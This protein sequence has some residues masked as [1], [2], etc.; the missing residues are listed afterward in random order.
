MISE[1]LAAQ[2]FRAVARTEAAPAELSPY[3]AE[4][5]DIGALTAIIDSEGG[6]T[7]RVVTFYQ[8]FYNRLPDGG[9]L[10]FWTGIARSD[11]N[12]SDGDLA[13]VFFGAGEFEVLYGDLSTEDAVRELYQNVLGREADEGGLAF[14][15]GLV[16]DP[17]NGFGLRDLGRAFATSDETTRTF[18]PLVRQYL[19][20]E[21]TGA[22]PPATLFDYDDGKPIAGT[23]FEGDTDKSGI[24]ATTIKLLEKSR[25]T[26]DTDPTI[27]RENQQSADVMRLDQLRADPMFAGIDGTGQTVAVLDTGIALDHPAFGT[28]TNGRAS[29]IVAQVD[30]TSDQDNSAQDSG[31]HGSNVS[32]IIAS[33]N[34]NYLGVAP[35]ANIAALQVLTGPRGNG[36]DGW[37]EAALQWV[38]ANHATYNI[39]VVNMSLGGFTNINT[40]QPASGGMADE[41]ARL[42]ELGIITVLSAGNSYYPFQVAAG[43][44]APGTSSLSVDPN[45]LSIG[46]VWDESIT[47]TA[48]Y[49]NGAKQFSS[50]PGDI[51]VFSQRAT[52]DAIESIFAPGAFIVG[53]AP[54]GGTVSQG[55]TSQ[56]A[57]NIAGLAVLAQEIAQKFLGRRLTPDEFERLLRETGQVITDNETARDNVAN[58]GETFRLADAHALAQAIVALGGPVPNPTPV[59]DVPGS[60]QTTETLGTA[61]P[62]DGILEQ[63]SDTDWY[64]ITLN[65]GAS[66]RFNLKGAPSGSGTLT[67][68]LLN[69][70]DANGRI[71]GTN[72]DRAAGARESLLE[73]NAPAS[74]TYFVEARAYSTETGTYR[75]SVSQTG[76]GDDFPRAITTPSTVTPGTPTTG[77]LE[78]PGDRDWHKLEVSAGTIY[79]IRLTGGNGPGQ[80]SDPILRLQ[81]AN[82][83]F[84][85]QNNNADGTLNSA[86]SY[87]AERSGT[88]FVDAGAFGNDK[89]GSYA[90]SVTQR[91][92]PPAEVPG[93][94]STNQRLRISSEGITGTLDQAGD[95][96]WYRIDLAAGTRYTLDLYGQATM[97]GTLADPLLRIFDAQGRQVAQNDD[98]GTSRNSTINF[99]PTETGTYYA[100]AE[101][102]AGQGTGTYRLRMIDQGFVLASLGESVAADVTT[103]EAL[104]ES[105]PV[106]GAIDME[107]DADWYEVAL[108]AGRTYTVSLAGESSGGGTLDDPYLR[109][110]DDAG[111]EV[112]FDDDGGTDFDA[113][114]VYTP[115]ADGSF[116]VSAEAFGDLSTGTYTLSLSSVVGGGAADQ[117]AADTTTDASVEA[118][119]PV[120]GALEFRGDRDWYRVTLAAGE[121]YDITLEGADGG[122]L[123]LSDP[124]LFIFDANGNEI[125]FDD[126]GLGGFDA[127][128][129][130]EP[131]YTGTYFIGAAAYEDNGLGSYRLT[132]SG[133]AV[134]MEEDSIRSG[135][136]TDLFFDRGFE[137]ED[138]IDFDGDEDWLAVDLFAGTEY[139]FSLDPS[140]VSGDPLGDPLLILY[141]ASGEPL[142]F[143][144]DT[145]LGDGLNSRLSF[146]PDEDGLYFISAAAI[147]DGTGGY[148]LGMA[149]AEDEGFDAF[150]FVEE[151][152]LGAL[153]F[154]GDIDWIEI[155]LTGGETY[156]I[157][158]YGD[159]E[160]LLEAGFGALEDPIVALIDDRGRLVAETTEAGSGFEVIL[161]ASVAEDGIYFVAIG[162]T[163]DTGEVGYELFVS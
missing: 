22:T 109:L 126:D 17:D 91:A 117:I 146:V 16:T 95:T 31:N 12:F 72:D 119:T 153:D 4:P 73:F 101:A 107:G 155:E 65:E 118:D 54:G 21:A 103:T 102:Y 84:I 77:R 98:N 149:Y 115:A 58:T 33:Q 93:D 114:L 64:R 148:R 161:S 61:S 110:Y 23:S 67:D 97:D 156:D 78:S 89:T 57:P 157:E 68:P 70:R 163:S 150:T 43:G 140:S 162:S 74:G 53:A 120:E 18:E 133:E 83:R 26:E 76:R 60:A 41:F 154:E 8:V 6:Q 56:A 143:N 128:L 85:T 129:F 9:G 137:L 25:N 27:L 159:Q 34:P 66:Y 47:G 69:L 158:V 71:V 7:S 20:A 35:D 50:S 87:T 62:I 81:D 92:A 135:P 132:V 136:D 1:E 122:E 145:P 152:F 44:P 19:E 36:Q 116:F 131:A 90:I 151:S 24:E 10:D 144:D 99:V 125:G 49:R 45:V 105:A 15:S 124:F 63:A 141:D 123:T 38:I 112:T 94:A 11:P 30:F 2:Y 96:D 113:E 79:D 29:R 104:T 121:I 80:L 51:T 106:T 42:K 37:I 82:G 59:A 55:G 138:Q 86:L 46:A 40:P 142:D 147:D 100:S 139:I 111:A 5:D 160:D 75:L 48:A 134:V 3:T 127:G 108:V 14:W 32:S 28:V 52:N 39:T 130:F 13:R 88:I